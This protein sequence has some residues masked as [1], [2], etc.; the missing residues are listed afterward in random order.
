MGEAGLVAGACGVR[1]NDGRHRP[2]RRAGGACG[3]APV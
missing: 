3:A 1:G 2:A